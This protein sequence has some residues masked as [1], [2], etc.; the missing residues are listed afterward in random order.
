MEVCTAIELDAVVSFIV[1]AE[2]LGDSVAQELCTAS[3]LRDQ[4]GAARRYMQDVKAPRQSHRLPWVCCFS[5]YGSIRSVLRESDDAN[6]AG[7]E[8]TGTDTGTDSSSDMRENGH[9]MDNDDDGA[10]ATDNDNDPTDGTGNANDGNEATDNYIDD[11]GATN[12]YNED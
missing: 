4:Q 3:T 8:D 12:E 11:I 5:S 7:D 9:S 1:E 2:L 6:A 10:D